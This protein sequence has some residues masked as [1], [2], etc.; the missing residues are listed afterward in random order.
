MKRSLLS[1]WLVGA[2]LYA[3]STLLL[4]NSINFPESNPFRT[5]PNSAEPQA[6]RSVPTQIPPAQTK[7]E[8]F[9]QSERIAAQGASSPPAH[10]ISTMPSAGERAIEETDRIRPHPADTSP[11]AAQ[12]S[13]ET[14]QAGPNSLPNQTESLQVA[15]AASIRK[16][17][18]TSHEIIG[19]LRSGAEVQVLRREAGWVQLNDPASDTMGWTYSKFLVSN[20]VTANTGAA[21]R[22]SAQVSTDELD[23]AKAT[24][25]QRGTAQSSAGL[26]SKQALPAEQPTMA[27]PSARATGNASI[28]TGDQRVAGSRPSDSAPSG[29]FKGLTGR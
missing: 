26:V 28:A 14:P 23:A 3:G 1:L 2:A 15:S 29:F 9:T 12:A 25:S 11:G 21:K 18:G 13:A 5:P 6:W 4:T 8:T 10:A 27:S 7:R 24:R 20:E 22:P 17:P 16:G 19:T